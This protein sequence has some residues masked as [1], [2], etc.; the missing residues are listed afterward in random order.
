MRDAQNGPALIKRVHK[1]A[2][3]D[4]QLLSGEAEAS[5]IMRYPFGNRRELIHWVATSTSMWVAEAPS[6]PC[7]IRGKWSVKVVLILV[8]YVY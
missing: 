3:I 8:H 1:E 5:V 4:I 2:G 7:L 6:L